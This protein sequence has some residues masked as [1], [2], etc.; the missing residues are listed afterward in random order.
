MLNGVR[1]GIGRLCRVLHYDVLLFGLHAGAV[2]C[3]S[4]ASRAPARVQRAMVCKL[5][6]ACRSARSLHTQ[7]VTDLQTHRAGR[8]HPAQRA[9]VRAAPGAPRRATLSAPEPEA[10]GDTASPPAGDR[11][12]ARAGAAARRMICGVR[13]HVPC[14]R[15][16]RGGWMS[17]GRGS[18]WPTRATLDKGEQLQT[19]GTG[20]SV[21]V[22]F[23]R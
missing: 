5:F 19:E 1:L 16:E 12:A 18:E 21:G 9:R 7:P 17:R 10:W 20:T 11:S 23:H 8:Q 2:S 15:G 22:T 3:D 13:E 4:Q 6:W 14:V